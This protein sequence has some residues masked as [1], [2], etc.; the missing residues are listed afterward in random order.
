MYIIR[1]MNSLISRMQFILQS[2][3]FTKANL[4]FSNFNLGDVT[5]ANSDAYKAANSFNYLTTDEQD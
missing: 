1:D 4:D 3:L 5:D 2:Y